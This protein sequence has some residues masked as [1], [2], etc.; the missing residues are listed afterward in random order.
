MEDEL[1]NLYLSSE[2]YDERR[3]LITTYA[4]KYDKTD[5]MVIAK[6]NKMGIYKPKPKISKVTGEKPQ[7][8]EQ[9]VTKI[10][11]LINEDLEGL[12]KAPKLVLMRLLRK[13]E[14]Y[15]N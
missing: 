11:A 14:E 7:T 5:R 15:V 1:K 4:K 9:I 8:K 12:E 6:L 3:E 13:L 2:D 10:A